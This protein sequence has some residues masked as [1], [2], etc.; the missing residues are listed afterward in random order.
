V[1]TN[2][3]YLK[4]KVGKDL[5][6]GDRGLFQRTLL[7]LPGQSYSDLISWLS[8]TNFSHVSGSLRVRMFA[9][10]LVIPRD[11]VIVLRLS[12]QILG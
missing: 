10:R 5:E 1:T 2:K 12:G 8:D 7:A 3:V 6:G 11:I 9:G 4:W